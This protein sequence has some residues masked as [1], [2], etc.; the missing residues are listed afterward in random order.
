MIINIKANEI[1]NTTSQVYPTSDLVFP[2]VPLMLFSYNEVMLGSI[3]ILCRDEG[4]P[5]PISLTAETCAVET[6][7]GN[8]PYT[9]IKLCVRSIETVTFLIMVSFVRITI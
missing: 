2:K 4:G 8:I 9:G 3:L 5:T 7:Y 6:L 1:R